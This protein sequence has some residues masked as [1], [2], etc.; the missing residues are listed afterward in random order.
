[1]RGGDMNPITEDHSLVAELVRSGD[2][3]RDQV[4]QLTEE[5]WEDP[6]KRRFALDLMG[7]IVGDRKAGFENDVRQFPRIDL[8]LPGV[9]TNTLLVRATAASA[10][11]RSWRVA[12]R[13]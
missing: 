2:L 4:K 6:N 9:G 11:T 8:G 12:A 10:D 1:M 5:V 13:R 3:T 7:T